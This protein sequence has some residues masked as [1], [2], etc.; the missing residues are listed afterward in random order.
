MQMLMRSMH[1]S[2]VLLWQCNTW[3][4]QNVWTVQFWYFSVTWKEL[5]YCLLCRRQQKVWFHLAGKAEPNPGNKTTKLCSLC[6]CQYT[7]KEKEWIPESPKVDMSLGGR[8][9]MSTFGWTLARKTTVSTWPSLQ[10]ARN[11]A[12]PACR[13]NVANQTESRQA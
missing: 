6:V 10:V 5:Q 9:M 1:C 4:D 8:H 13:T 3:W 12:R 7:L 2:S 11:G